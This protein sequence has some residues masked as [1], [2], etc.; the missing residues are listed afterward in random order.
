MVVLIISASWLTYMTLEFLYH[1]VEQ[2][3][4]VLFPRY[5]A[6]MNLGL[7]KIGT[8]KRQWG[9]YFEGCNPV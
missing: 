4:S 5:R 2:M 7:F 1:F 9:F 3:T 8:R 6:R